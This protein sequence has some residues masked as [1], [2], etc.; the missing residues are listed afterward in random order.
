VVEAFIIALGTCLINNRVDLSLSSSNRR[1][2][3]SAGLALD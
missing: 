3:S 1:T 2:L